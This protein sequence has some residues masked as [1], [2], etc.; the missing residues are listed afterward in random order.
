MISVKKLSSK[1]VQERYIGSYIGKFSNESGN[2]K[3]KS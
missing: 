3:I 1:N 2:K